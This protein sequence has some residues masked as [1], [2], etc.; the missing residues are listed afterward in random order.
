MSKNNEEP[1]DLTEAAKIAMLS[2]ALIKEFG[3]DACDVIERQIEA[4]ESDSD[5][6]KWIAIWEIL[7]SPKARR[8]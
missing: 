6:A 8:A 1:E 2:D 7:C 3:A 5:R 4:H